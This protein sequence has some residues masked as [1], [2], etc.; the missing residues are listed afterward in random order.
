MNFEFRALC[1]L[2]E[3][4][5]TKTLEAKARQTCDQGRRVEETGNSTSVT[6]AHRFSTAVYKIYN[7]RGSESLR[8]E[9]RAISCSFHSTSLVPGMLFS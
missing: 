7:A 3:T 9:P 1:C 6:P 4:L 5:K 2:L 8:G